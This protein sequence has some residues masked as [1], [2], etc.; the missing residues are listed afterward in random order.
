VRRNL[1][2]LLREQMLD[3]TTCS[4]LLAEHVSNT[5]PRQQT[6]RREAMAIAAYHAETEFAVVRL[7]GRD[8]APQFA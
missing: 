1:A 7:P 4:R 5:G 3:E 6:R 2:H 8:D